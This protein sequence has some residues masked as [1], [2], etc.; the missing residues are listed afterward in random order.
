MAEETR[1]SGPASEGAA[2]A[3]PS[4]AKGSGLDLIEL[5]GSSTAIFADVLRGALARLE[6]TA[7][8]AAGTVYRFEQG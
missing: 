2:T 5:M 4:T 6:R 8:T 3:A 1:T 7:P